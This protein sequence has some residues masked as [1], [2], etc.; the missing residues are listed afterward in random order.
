MDNKI[1]FEK[2]NEEY[3]EI[4]KKWWH[5]ER[6]KAFW[7]NSPEMEQDVDNYVKKGQKTYYDY[8]KGG[9]K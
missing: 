1:T 6:V 8:Y 4:L 9:K 3:Y 5:S 2:L 7:D